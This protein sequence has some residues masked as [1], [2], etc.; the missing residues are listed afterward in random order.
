MHSGSLWYFSFSSVVTFIVRTREL[1]DKRNVGGSHVVGRR[2]RRMG[3][4]SGLRGLG[5]KREHREGDLRLVM[6][7]DF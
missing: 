7:D 3:Q 4:G 2:G 6:G 5:K 1:D